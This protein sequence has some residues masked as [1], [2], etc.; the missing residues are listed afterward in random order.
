MRVR[1]I[2]RLLFGICLVAG[3]AA[4][5]GK[6]PAGPPPGAPPS[7]SRG[8]GGPGGP[9]NAG[10][11]GGGGATGAPGGST[12]SGSSSGNVQHFG[13]VGR[14]W[15]DKA[16]VRTVGLSTDQQ[17]KMDVIF[18]ANKGA[19]VATYKT[20]L[21]E[22]AKLDAISKQ[23]QVDQ[24]KMFAA[25]DAVSQARVALLKANTQMLLQIREQMNAD[26]IAKLETLK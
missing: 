2:G 9:P 6:P 15:D 3:S 5:Q 13:P 23:S 12:T 8:P 1:A 22:Q 25:I 4:A 16:V 17:K 26:Q 21:A 11:P 14:W 7:G 20:F 10:G 19:I 24:S 18:N